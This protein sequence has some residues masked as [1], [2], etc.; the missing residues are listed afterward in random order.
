VS[1]EARVPVAEAVAG[2]VAGRGRA[3]S[4]ARRGHPRHRSGCIKVVNS[5][6]AAV[7]KGTSRTNPTKEELDELEIAGKALEDVDAGCKASQGGIRVAQTKRS[8]QVPDKSL[9]RPS[10]GSPLAPAWRSASV[11]TLR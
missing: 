4:C 1:S 5:K 6:F 10:T 3:R 11:S 7:A 8:Y 2:P 9:G